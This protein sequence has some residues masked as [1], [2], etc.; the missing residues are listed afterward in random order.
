MRKF[1]LLILLSLSYSLTFAQGFEGTVQLQVEGTMSS[2]ENV[3]ANEDVDS[4]SKRKEEINETILF[5]IKGN[6]SHFVINE[7]GTQMTMI[8]DKATGDVIQVI[9]EDGEK[10]A[11]KINFKAMIEANKAK[12]SKSKPTTVTKTGK[13]KNIRGYVCDEQ[14]VKSEG[15]NAIVWTTDKVDLNMNEQIPLPG[16]GSLFAANFENIH[17]FVMEMNSEDAEGNKLS[18]KATVEE[19]T[20]DDS[21]FVPDVNDDEKTKMS[22]QEKMMQLIQKYRQKMLDAADDEEKIKQLTEELVSKMKEFQN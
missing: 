9:E 21:I 15:F 19:K 16:D 7:Q 12:E 6:M 11:M 13:S 3:Y 22:N 20:I 14:I 1:N 17:D 8:S 5:Q 4:K 18:W 2:I 10:M